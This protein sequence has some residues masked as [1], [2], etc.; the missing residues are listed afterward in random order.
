MKRRNA[1]CN[2]ARVPSL[3]HT[4]PFDSFEMEDK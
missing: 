4:Y 1:Y 2:Y 3:N